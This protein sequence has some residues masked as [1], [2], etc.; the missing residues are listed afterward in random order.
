MASLVKN[1]P[2]LPATRRAPSGIIELCD[3]GL[4]V[5]TA[6]GV[7]ELLWDQVTEVRPVHDDAG[8]VAIV[9]GGVHGESVSFDRSVRG[10]A[11]LLRLL[12]ESRPRSLAP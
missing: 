11:E 9:V 6:D 1:A 10:L 7:L 12:D 4:R 2:S 3:G 8:L 5:S